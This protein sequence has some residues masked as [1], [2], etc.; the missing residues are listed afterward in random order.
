MTKLRFFLICFGV[1]FIT[2]TAI[3]IATDQPLIFQPVSY[4]I[5]DFMFLAILIGILCIGLVFV[6]LP[7]LN[8]IRRYFTSLKEG[9]AF[10]I[11]GIFII[12]QLITLVAGYLES[13]FTL[14]N[15]ADWL[16]YY[17]GAGNSLVYIFTGNCTAILAAMLY[18]QE[19]Q[20]RKIEPTFDFDEESSVPGK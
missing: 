17:K 9:F 4:A 16:Y 10:Y 19:D 1:A 11:I 13:K 6:A 8:R 12:L 3:C 7:V 2:T 5:K 18:A 14:H 15:Q 20:K